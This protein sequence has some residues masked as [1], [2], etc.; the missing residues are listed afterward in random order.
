MGVGV[1]EETTVANTKM[2]REKWGG[3]PL[4]IVRRLQAV[5]FEK[6]AG[7][8][9]FLHPGSET[10]TK[11]KNAGYISIWELSGA[12]TFEVEDALGSHGEAAVNTCE[13]IDE[14]LQCA[15]EAAGLTYGMLDEGPNCIPGLIW[16][17]QENIKRGLISMPEREKERE[18]KEMEEVRTAGAGEILLKDVVSPRILLTLTNGLPNITTLNQIASMGSGYKGAAEIIQGLGG[19]KKA[20]RGIGTLN[21]Q[22]EVHNLPGPILSAKNPQVKKM[23]EGEM[24]EGD[25]RARPL[26][27]EPRRAKDESTEIIYKPVEP[28]SPTQ[29]PVMLSSNLTQLVAELTAAIVDLSAAVTKRVGPENEIL[30]IA[31]PV[32]AKFGYKEGIKKIEAAVAFLLEV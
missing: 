7:N 23:L 18:G 30:T 9:V 10:I 14:I 15:I 8:W 31:A 5:G 21:R 24:P 6:I 25:V 32:I 12:T 3:L 13:V 19:P 1:L 16:P 26:G 11:L 22:L 28:S 4:Q 17:T 20:S 27:T 29:K 2:D